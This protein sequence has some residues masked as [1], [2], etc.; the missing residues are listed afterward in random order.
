VPCMIREDTVLDFV[1]GEWR[2]YCSETCHWTDKVAFREE[3]NGRPT[4]AMGRLTGKREW[5]TLYHGWDLEDVFKDLGY[6]RND[7]KTLVPQPH[8]LFDDS[9][10]W[11]L[12]HVRGIEFQSPRV[13]INEMS[14]D[15]REKWYEEYKQGFTIKES[16]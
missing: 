7:D 3:Y 5:E 15:E 12:D 6:V 11:T 14:D 1:D 9:K 8:V 4:P 16:L 2:T 10:M 13:L